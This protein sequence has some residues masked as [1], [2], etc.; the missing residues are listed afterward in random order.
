HFDTFRGILG[1]RGGLIAMEQRILNLISEYLDGRLRLSEFQ[2]RFAGCY[3]QVRNNGAAGS[4][5]E[6]CNKVIGPLA[7]L[8]RGHRSEE[9]LQQELTAA[10]RPF[11]PRG[12]I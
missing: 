5:S 1:S 2:Q 4:A 9:S 12:A 11:A 8:S 6:L 3:L 10:I 7:E